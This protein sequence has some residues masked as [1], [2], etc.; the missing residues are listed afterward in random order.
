MNLTF[1][2]VSVGIIVAAIAW[3]L[4][5]IHK[6][7]VLENEKKRREIEQDAK[8]KINSMSISDLVGDSNRRSAR[9]NSST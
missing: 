5:I 1:L 2:S 6:N 9:R 8:S 7:Q 4:S 3:L